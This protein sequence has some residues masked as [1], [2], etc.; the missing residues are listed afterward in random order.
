M[1]DGFV[2]VAQCVEGL[3]HGRCHWE[4]LIVAFLA[5]FLLG[6]INESTPLAFSFISTD[7]ATGETGIAL[8]SAMLTLGNFLAILVGGWAADKYGRLEVARPALLATVM[9]GLLLH[10][11]RSLPQAMVSRFLLGLASGGLLGVIPALVSEMLPSKDRGFYLSIFC[12]GWP[13]GALYALGMGALFPNLSFRTFYSVML[14]PSAVL[15]AAL[16]ADMLP[17]SPRYL[18]LAG[19]RDDGY[20]ALLDMYDKQDCLFPWAPETIAI[21]CKQSRGSGPP[22]ASGS[23]GVAGALRQPSSACTD[24][25]TLTAT[26]PSKTHTSVLATSVWLAIAVFSLSAAS[27]SVKLW[28]PTMLSAEQASNGVA[29]GLADTSAPSASPWSPG[30]HGVAPGL[31]ATYLRFAQAPSAVSLMNYAIAPRMMAKPNRTVLMVLAQ[32]YTIELIGV[33]IA[34]FVCAHVSRKR[35]VQCSLLSATVLCVLTLA[36]AEGGYLMACGPLIG[37]QL[38]CQSTAYNFLQVFVCEHFPTSRRAKAIAM[39]VFFAQFGN[40]TM[41][42]V[43][44]LVVRQIS[45]TAA[46]LL[47]G[48]CYFIGWLASLRLPL[49]VGPEQPLHDVDEPN[50]RGPCQPVARKEEWLTYQTL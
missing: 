13:L 19:R 40:L 20:A 45:P 10:M 16:K 28:M 26:V 47:F 24:R 44:G 18:Y 7:W 32:A 12:A 50:G 2:T 15:F 17:E 4:A 41:P 38:A 46:M 21:T 37:L 49:P 14:V 34:A 30:P 42:M 33:I 36:A 35:M 22:G 31:A 43:G 48:V 8:L 3:P 1:S 6:A 11:S 25:A 5:W 39:A 29:P 23:A 27:Q 9:C